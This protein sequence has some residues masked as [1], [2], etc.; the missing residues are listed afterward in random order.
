MHYDCSLSLNRNLLSWNPQLAHPER[1]A[2]YFYPIHLP[3]KLYPQGAW[4]VQR[5]Y[6]L[7]QSCR[8]WITDI[9]KV[10]II[11]FALRLI[12]AKFK[13]PIPHTTT[14]PPRC[15]KLFQ[16]VSLDILNL[17]MISKLFFHSV[18]IYGPK[19]DMILKVLFILYAHSK[20]WIVY[21][22]LM[23]IN[24]LVLCFH[25]KPQ[26][27]GLRATKIIHSKVCL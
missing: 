13:L 26:L 27:W 3:A 24:M 1:T 4:E 8:S 5:Q 21:I 9:L 16:N 15:T 6:Q 7:V 18:R 25:C 19:T 2:P 20:F 22:L 23:I 17:M 11:I 10:R 12:G 14:K